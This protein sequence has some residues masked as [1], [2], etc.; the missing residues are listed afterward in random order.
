MERRD[1]S[2]RARKENNR[3]SFYTE[4]VRFDLDQIK[5]HFDDSLSVISEQLLV[6]HELQEKGRESVAYYLWRAQIVFLASAFDFFIHELAKFGLCQIHEGSWADTQKYENIQISLK[7]AILAIDSLQSID[8]FLDFINGYLSDKTMIS[9]EAVKDILNMIGLSLADVAEKAFYQRGAQE[10]PLERMKRSLNG[11]YRRRNAIA[12]Q[13]DRRH[14]DAQSS[15]IS[16]Q[17]VLDY[18]AEIRKITDSMLDEARAK[19]S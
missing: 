18:I 9:Y 12:H 6:A 13:M 10:K 5:K 1:L 19:V 16:E 8:W 14:A 3:D 11:L 7:Q 17:L 15:G 2:P 4:V